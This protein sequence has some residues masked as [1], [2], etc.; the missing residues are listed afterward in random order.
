MLADAGFWAHNMAQNASGQPADVIAVR[1]GKS[2]LIDCKVCSDGRFPLYRV[3]ENQKLA[4]MLWQECGNGQGWFALN[5]DG[6][7]YMVEYIVLMELKQ[8][9]AVM[10]TDLILTK[11]ILFSEW[12]KR[13]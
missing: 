12:I 3:E 7:V 4:M 9:I 5:L 11:G 2:Y 10:N 1:D 6:L 13:Q 8:H